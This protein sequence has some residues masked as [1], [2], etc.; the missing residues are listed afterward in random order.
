MKSIRAKNPSRYRLRLQQRL[1]LQYESEVIARL[2]GQVT[3]FGVCS[4]ELVR[5]GTETPEEDFG[6]SM[7]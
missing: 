2:S 3:E 1:H 5:L 7:F 6:M 4:V